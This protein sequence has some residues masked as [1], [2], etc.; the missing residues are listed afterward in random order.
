MTEDVDLLDFHRGSYVTSE[1]HAE[2]V[3]GVP[4]GLR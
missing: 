2:P 1:R 3:R 4:P